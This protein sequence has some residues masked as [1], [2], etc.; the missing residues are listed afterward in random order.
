[1]EPTQGDHVLVYLTSPTFHHLLPVLEQM[2]GP[3]I[4]YGL[5]SRQAVK[6]IL[7]KNPSSREF[8]EDLA[9]CR[10][11]VTN[12][13][14]NV[15]S[16]AL[17]LGKP[18]FAFPI[19]LAYEQ[20]FNAHMVKSLGYGDYSLASRPHLNLFDAFEKQ[21]DRFQARIA[22]GSFAGNEKL[23]GRL[24]EIIR[25]RNLSWKGLSGKDPGVRK[26]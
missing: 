23:V 25:T 3:F 19:H 7:F 11:A 1:M 5:E 21:L 17:I 16:E 10:Y 4:V 14:H 2:P 13:G 26:G 9:S 22:E 20:F 12:A 15:I 18:V 6:N 8:L 24:E